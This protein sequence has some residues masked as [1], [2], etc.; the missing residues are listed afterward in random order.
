MKMMLLVVGWMMCSGNLHGAEDIPI[1]DS[2]EA[3]RNWEAVGAA[4]AKHDAADSRQGRHVT[5]TLTSPEFTLDRKHLNFVIGGG[6]SKKLRFEL[7]VAGQVV[8]SA[9]STTGPNNL[10]PSGWN[11][12]EFKGKS[13]RLRL[14]DEEISGIE[15]ICVDRVVLSDHPAPA[16]LENL[17]R[18]R[19]TSSGSMIRTGLTIST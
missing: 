9:G 15:H 8:R 16:I 2:R 3:W 4:F 17:T 11:V 6:W 12:E 5:G 1:A 13:A 14:V 7:L 10:D 18:A 19:G